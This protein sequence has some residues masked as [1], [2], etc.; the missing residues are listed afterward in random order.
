MTHYVYE[1]PSGQ[2][3]NRQI[4]AYGTYGDA[5]EFARV[6]RQK[7]ALGEDTLILV[8]YAENAEQADASAAQ[9]R[10]KFDEARSARQAPGARVALFKLEYPVEAEEPER[11]PLRIATGTAVLEDHRERSRPN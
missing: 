9:L 3:P 4:G 10:G 7:L 6:E 2:L 8:V 1:I 5:S 11:Q